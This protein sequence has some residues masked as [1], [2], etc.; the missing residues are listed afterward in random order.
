[1]QY[2]TKDTRDV[3]IYD[4]EIKAKHK[5]MSFTKRD[6]II[7]H[8]KL[9]DESLFYIKDTKDIIVNSKIS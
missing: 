1:M 4:F 8:I 9:L 3:Y 6:G 2:V 7:S 5:V